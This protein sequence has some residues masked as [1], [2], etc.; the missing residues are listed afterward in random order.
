M[1][2][3]VTNTSS[4]GMLIGAYYDNVSAPKCQAYTQNNKFSIAG[5]S[6]NITSDTTCTANQM[7]NLTLTASAASMNIDVP[8]WLFARSNDINNIIRHPGLKIYNTKIYSNNTLT[9]D[10]VPAQY[11]G[12]YGMW[13]LVEDKFYKNAGTGSF[14]VG[15]EMKNYDEIYEVRK[16]SSLLPAGVELY[17][18]I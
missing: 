18:Y 11:N 5:F 15:P 4:I 10:F 17:D 14:T 16:T 7:Y 2:F 12:Q 3:I 1:S 13:D 6:S 8:L 9:R